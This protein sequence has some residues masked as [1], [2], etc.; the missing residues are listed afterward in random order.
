MSSV[1]DPDDNRSGLSS[2]AERKLTD[3]L[4]DLRNR[5]AALADPETE[6][7]VADSGDN[8]EAL[9]RADERARVEDRITEI[10]RLVNPAAAGAGAGEEP[11][12][13]RLNGASVTLRGEDGSSQS[14]RIVTSA[15]ARVADDD[16]QVLSVQSPL[17]QALIDAEQGDTIQYVTPDGE[18]KATVA[19]LELI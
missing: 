18:R 4:T 3:E 19:R 8:A 1:T 14:F 17:G 9:R 6:D 10:E 5:R 16:D 12:E 15:E 13:R 11:G 2:E 7:A